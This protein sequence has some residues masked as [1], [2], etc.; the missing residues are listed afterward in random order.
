VNSKSAKRL[1][2][3]TVAVSEQSK[4][5]VL[6]T[7]V[8]VM[9]A[10]SFLLSEDNRSLGAFREVLEH[11]YLPPGKEATFGVLLMDGLLAHV[12]LLGDLLPRPPQPSRIRDLEDLQLFHQTSKRGHGSKTDPG[13]AAARLARDLRCLSHA[14]NI[15]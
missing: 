12:E 9:Q 8:S 4:K 1:V 5:E 2:P 13:I 10:E 3:D 14:V 15:R 7:D 11:G 6:R